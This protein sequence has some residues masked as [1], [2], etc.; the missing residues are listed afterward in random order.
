VEV[1]KGVQSE[2]VVRKT[3]KKMP[4][5]TE[6]W[7]SDGS[8]E[9]CLVT[10]RAS[11]TSCVD[12]LRRILHHA[13]VTTFPLKCHRDKE[14]IAKSYHSFFICV[15]LHA[16]LLA[17]SIYITRFVGNS[18]PYIV[19][20]LAMRFFSQAHRPRRHSSAATLPDWL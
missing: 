15:N 16:V 4:I 9:V 20:Q 7:R 3:L 19:S 12:Q 5:M 10:S 14:S 17:L 1:F 2:I 13:A 11:S 6:Q 18:Q 8:F